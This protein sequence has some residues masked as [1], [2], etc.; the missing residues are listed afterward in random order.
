LAAPGR[1]LLAEP[2]PELVEL[3]VL[4]LPADRV[5]GPGPG[6]EDEGGVLVRGVG[7]VTIGGATGLGTGG[8]ATRGVVAAG[9]VTVT[10]GG[11]GSGGGTVTGGGAIVT[12]GTVT[13]GGGGSAV[14]T[15]SDGTVTVTPGSGGTCR[16]RAC[17]AAKPASAASRPTNFAKRDI[18]RYN[19][20]PP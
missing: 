19:G 6:D 15:G 3:G 1:E 11:D 10:G 5:A 9:V 4:A 20:R 7:V 2:L 18:R 13:G 17:A 8:G 16:A 14:V 12:G